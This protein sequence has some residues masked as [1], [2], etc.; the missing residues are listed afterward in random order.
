MLKYE[1]SDIGAIVTHFQDRAADAERVAA[2]TPTKRQRDLSQREA[3]VWRQCA[4]ILRNTKI[5]PGC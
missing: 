1:A 4:D 5:T 2:R 3:F